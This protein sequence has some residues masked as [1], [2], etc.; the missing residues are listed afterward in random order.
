VLKKFSFISGIW[1][2]MPKNNFRDPDNNEISNFYF[3]PVIIH[4]AG[5]QRKNRLKFIKEYN[6]LFI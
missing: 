4:L 1:N 5:I 6:H 3:D 2:S